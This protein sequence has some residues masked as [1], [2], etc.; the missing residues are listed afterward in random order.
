[1]AN[2]DSESQAD[3]AIFNTSSV[4]T[5]PEVVQ[6]EHQTAQLSSTIPGPSRPPSEALAD[7]TQSGTQ[8]E[9]MISA[10]Y[11]EEDDPGGTNQGDQ[12]QDTKLGTSAERSAAPRK[13]KRF[14]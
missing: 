11:E 13:M 4:P 12:D 2:F 6:V 10:K 8:D 5:I 7:H 9:E 14:R 1:M 3:Q